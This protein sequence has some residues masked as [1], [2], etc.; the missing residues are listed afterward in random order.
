MQVKKVSLTDFLEN[1][2]QGTKIIAPK[3]NLIKILEKNR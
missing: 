1:T 2:K 3:G